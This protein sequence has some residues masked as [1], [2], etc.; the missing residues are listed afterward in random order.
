MS[1]RWRL[2][3]LLQVVVS[4]RLTGQL[5]RDVE[6]H[7]VNPDTVHVGR[8]VIKHCWEAGP[9]FPE[10]LFSHAALHVSAL[11]GFSYSTDCR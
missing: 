8:A 2:V 11:E 6:A 5:R 10:S 9:S 7:T 3:G 1:F 4:Q